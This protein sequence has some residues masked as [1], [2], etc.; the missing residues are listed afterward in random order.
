MFEQVQRPTTRSAAR[1]RS[2]LG[3]PRGPPECQR[4][5]Q[6]IRARKADD[7]RATLARG[8]SYG[9]GQLKAQ[10][11]PTSVVHRGGLMDGR[12]SPDDVEQ[13]ECGR[14]VV[15]SRDV[16]PPLVDANLKPFLGDETECG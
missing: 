3:E 12:A 8:P 15:L 16:N 13:G 14:L 1:E 4:S 2:D 6:V 7:G 10:F 5:T 9:F 11:P